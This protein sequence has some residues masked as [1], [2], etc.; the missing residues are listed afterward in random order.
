MHAIITA[1][2][3]EAADSAL[4]VLRGALDVHSMLAA[5]EPDVRT[6]GLSQTVD[7]VQKACVSLIA[8]LEARCAAL[9]PRHCHRLTAPCVASTLRM[10]CRRWT[11][12][13][14]RSG[15]ACVALH[16]ILPDCRARL[17]A[18]YS[19]GKRCRMCFRQPVVGAC[20]PLA[21]RRVTAAFF[22]PEAL[23]Q[24][25][26]DRHCRPAQRR[27]IQ[28][29]ERVEPQRACHRDCQAGHNA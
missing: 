28:L 3:L 20:S 21:C 1:Q 7:G 17:S 6:G 29:A 22:E 13:A 5:A 23:T 26:P 15:A 24:A 8:E 27:Q 16:A 11:K 12:R 14:L 9:R 2:T 18:R 10:T 4:A 19:C 25:S